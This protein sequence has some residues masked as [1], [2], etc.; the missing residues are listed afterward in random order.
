M[1]NLSG[2]IPPLIYN[3]SSINYFY[4]TQ[5]QLHGSL[6]PELGLTLPNLRQFAG[7]AN[8]F[9]GPIPV[10]LSNAFQL[11]IFDLPQNGL[12][13]TVAQ[14]INSLQGLVRFNL[15]ENKLGKGKDGDLNFLSFL[16][17]CTSLEVLGLRGNHFGGLLPNSI[18]NLSIKLKLLTM[19]DNMIHGGIPVGIGNLVNLNLLGLEV[20]YLG[21]PLPNALGKLQNLEELHLNVN[22]FSGLIPSFLGNLTTLTRL[23]MGENKFEGAIPPSL[24]NCKNLIVLNLSSSNLNGTIP[25]QVIGLSSLS[26]YLVMSKNFLTS[27]LPFEVGNLKNLVHLDLLENRLSGEIPTILKTCLGLV[28]LYLEGKFSRQIPNFLSKLSSLKYLNIS[29]N[30]FGAK[31]QLKEFFQM[32]ARFQY[33]EMI[34]YAVVS[35]NYIYLNAP[36]KILVHL[37]GFLP[38]K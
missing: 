33:L 27:T 34:S 17:N 7:G 28:R 12:T 13:G 1:N 16:A 35:K 22:E 36:A 37:G 20:N 29:Y 24:G 15:Q 11:Q 3:V 38:S 14:N 18:A 2:V 32:Q 23:F 5:N 9:T 30:D 10:S 31:C 8:S 25:K 21:G 26:L 6:P 4:V 19:G